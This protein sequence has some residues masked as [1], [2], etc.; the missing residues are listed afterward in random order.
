MAPDFRHSFTRPGCE[1]MNTAIPRIILVVLL[2]ASIAAP[3]VAEM[4]VGGEI[5]YRVQKGD[6]LQTVAA[7]N[8]IFWRNIA[9][10]NSFDGHAPLLQGTE[11]LLNTRRIVPRRIE[12]GIIVN[13]PDR[14]L[15]YFKNGK[16]TFFP[17]GV[18]SHSAKGGADWRTPTGKFWVR[19]KRKNPVWYVPSSIIVESRIRGEGLGERVA[20]GPKNPL[21][22]YAVETS[23]PGLL[24]HGTI[25]P[26]SVYRYSTHGCLRMLPQHMKEFYSMVET[27]AQGEI[28]YE[29]VK[30]AV[31]DAGR[32]YLEVRTD[33]YRRNGPP[34]DEALRIIESKGLAK[35]VDWTKVDR[36]VHDQTGIAEDITLPAPEPVPVPKQ[37]NDTAN[38]N[39]AFRKLLDFIR[40]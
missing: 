22:S 15:Y 19:G 29:P 6:D 35:K 32:I 27:G 4:I 9:L 1:S 39:L 18:G 33:M 36:I 28:I 23:I 31:T 14:T 34:R 16:L 17:V 2:I 21:G 20:P 10:A 26:G 8:G 13:I 12:N 24:I 40:F 7:K 38:K 5:V 25:A 37:R 30:L 11:L 3:A